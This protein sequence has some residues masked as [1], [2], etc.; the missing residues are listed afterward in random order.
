MK[1]IIIGENLN[2]DTK[3]FGEYNNI[4]DAQ[5]D[6]DEIN[7]QQRERNKYDDKL[8]NIF[9]ELRLVIEMITIPEPDNNDYNWD[10]FF[11]NEYWLSS[12]NIMI[13]TIHY[14]KD[15]INEKLGYYPDDNQINE[16]YDK[17]ISDSFLN[18]YNSF[19]I[20]EK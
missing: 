12:K 10:K 14:Y 6:L 15:I 2:E 1:Y 20:I 13:K 11:E 17:F 8:Y 3:I 16:I 9:N 4:E 5:H 7:I 19:K 18:E